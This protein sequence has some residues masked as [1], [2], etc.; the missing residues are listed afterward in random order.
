MSLQIEALK[1]A[2][3]EAEHLRTDRARL[4]G[5][6]DATMQELEDVRRH[7]RD[8]LDRL[9]QQS[10]ALLYALNQFKTK[11]ADATVYDQVRQESG[12]LWVTGE[13]VATP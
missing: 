5:D 6:Y 8:A 3:E 2:R 10:D 7:H 4:Q 9:T 11:G 1:N 12:R 13:R